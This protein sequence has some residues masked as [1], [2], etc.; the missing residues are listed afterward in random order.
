MRPPA[1]RWTLG[2]TD[3]APGSGISGR[4]SSKPL[5]W[6]RSEARRTRIF[7]KADHRIAYPI[8]SVIEVSGAHL[9]AG[10]AAVVVRRSRDG[11]FQPAARWS[12]RPIGRFGCYIR[13]RVTAVLCLTCQA[14]V[15]GVASVKHTIGMA[16]AIYSAFEGEDAGLRGCNRGSSSKMAINGISRAAC[17]KQPPNICFTPQPITITADPDQS[18]GGAQSRS[19]EGPHGARA[20][21]RRRLR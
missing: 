11:V 5:A 19:G 10:Y 1:A 20:F 7:L 9:L 3:T 16:R 15:C 13:P 4:K 8:H 12:S 2:F 14:T 17:M 6:F 21:R 18:A